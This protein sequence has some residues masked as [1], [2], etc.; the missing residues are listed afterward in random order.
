MIDIDADTRKMRSLGWLRRPELDED[1][2]KHG[3]RNWAEFWELQDGR[4]HRRL[5][6]ISPSRDPEYIGA[7]RQVKKWSWHGFVC[8]FCTEMNVAV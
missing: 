3:K 5:W 2:I 6:I 7:T 1:R 4:L 8:C